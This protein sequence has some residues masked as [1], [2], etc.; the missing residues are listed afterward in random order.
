MM[1]NQHPL[2]IRVSTVPL[3]LHKLLKG[4]MRYMQENG[5]R[6]HLVSSQG[7]EIPAIIESEGCGFTTIPM[8]RN[9]SPVQDFLSLIRLMVLFLK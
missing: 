7:P 1:E 9:I 5:F 6:L 4:Q 3:S 2:L 8:T